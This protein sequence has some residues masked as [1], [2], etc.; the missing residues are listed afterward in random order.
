MV[1]WVYL[2]LQN[3]QK[4]KIIMCEFAR[5]NT[6]TGKHEC[7]VLTNLAGGPC[8]VA[9]KEKIE[10]TI[11][12]MGG[13]CTPEQ[14]LKCGNAESQRYSDAAFHRPQRRANITGRRDDI[15]GVSRAHYQRDKR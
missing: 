13:K 10:D 9:N 1:F 14:Q 11:R 2:G 12:E 15:L 3:T 4:D 6:L 7:P 5:Y 8:G